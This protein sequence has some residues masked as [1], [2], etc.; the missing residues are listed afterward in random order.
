[1]G[2]IFQNVNYHGLFLKAK[3]YLSHLFCTVICIR[4]QAYIES[5]FKSCKNLF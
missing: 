5:F 2:G 4:I 1:M 3:P